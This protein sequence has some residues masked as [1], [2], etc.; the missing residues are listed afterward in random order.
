MLLITIL[1][2]EEPTVEVTLSPFTR[3]DFRKFAVVV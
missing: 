1:S 2:I 3:E